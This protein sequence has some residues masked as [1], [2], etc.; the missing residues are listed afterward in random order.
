MTFLLVRDWRTRVIGEVAGMVEVQ[1]FLKNNNER[2]DMLL[3]DTDHNPLSTGGNEETDWLAQLPDSLSAQRFPPVILGIGLHGDGRVLHQMAHHL[4]VGY[5]LKDEIRY[6]LAWAASLAAGG[7]WVMTPGVE[8]LL[9]SAG[10]ALPAK[11]LVLDGRALMYDFTESEA[12]VARL[13]FLF[14]VERRDLADELKIS[15]AWSYGVVSG[16]YDKLGMDA[17]VNGQVD[18]TEYLGDN[19]L[20]LAHLKEIVQRLGHSKKAQDMETLAFHLL[21]MPDIR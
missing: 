16:I 21:T 1:A 9:A 12:R 7:H 13:A 6:S 20:V 18:P 2:I 3:V 11:R 10:I 14:S 5:L 8:P 4:F 15:K 17:I 19:P